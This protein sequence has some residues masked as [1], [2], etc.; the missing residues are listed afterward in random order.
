MLQD[1]AQSNEVTYSEW[2]A[3]PCR[4]LAKTSSTFS[5]VTDRG[6]P[7]RQHPGARLSRSAKLGQITRGDERDFS[8]SKSPLSVMRMAES[9][10]GG[11]LVEGGFE[12]CAEV[13]RGGGCCG[14]RRRPPRGGE[15]AEEGAGRDL[16]VGRHGE[17]VRLDERVHG[18]GHAGVVHPRPHVR[19]SWPTSRWRAESESV[20]EAEPDV[21]VAA[22]AFDTATFASRGGVGV[23]ESVRV[24]RRGRSGVGLPRGGDK[25]DGGGVGAVRS[26]GEG[27]GGGRSQAACRGRRRGP[28]ARDG[29]RRAS[30][31]TAFNTVWTAHVRRSRRGRCP[32]E[33]WRRGRD[34]EASGGRKERRR[35]R[36]SGSL[37]MARRSGCRCGLSFDVRRVRSSVQKPRKGS[38]DGEEVEWPRSWAT[39]PSRRRICTL[40]EFFG[41]FGDGG[42]RGSS[43]RSGGSCRGRSRRAMGRGRPRGLRRDLGQDA[44]SP[45]STPGV[46]E[47]GEA[48]HA[49]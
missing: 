16:A 32:P 41:G 3:V 39:D 8:A 22:V 24:G 13:A 36:A 29:R 20:H 9:R 27:V 4:Q 47:F 14:A 38:G 33:A 37:A 35:D 7:P 6:P 30:P 26:D 12:G 18:G 46:H 43:G 2:C 17:S 23:L 48:E 15:R 25:V 45:S 19:A 40:A 49:G 21:V 5:T 34:Q 44:G 28:G 1:L 42:L 31:D 11:E 10:R